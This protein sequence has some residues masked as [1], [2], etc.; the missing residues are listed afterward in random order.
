M[1]G[2]RSLRRIKDSNGDRR[3]VI[4]QCRITKDRLT[5]DSQFHHLRQFAKAPG[6]HAGDWR[7]CQRCHV[8][9]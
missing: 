4:L 7:R 8:I 5:I 6:R 1:Y 3:I 9:I 2:T